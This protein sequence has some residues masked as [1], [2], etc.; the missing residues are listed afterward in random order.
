[1]PRLMAYVAPAD[2]ASARSVK[3]GRAITLAVLVVLIA[4]AAYQAAVA[5]GWLS[6]GPLPGQAP[7]GYGLVLGAALLALVVGAGLCAVYASWPR[8][9]ADA[10]AGLIGPA[11]AAFVVARFY[12][13]DPYY[14]PTLRRMSDDGLVPES[15]VYAVIALA[16]LTAVLAGLR[17]RVALTL[18][19]L[20]LL[21]SAVTALAAGLGH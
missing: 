10:L 12:S 15:W 9:P 19:T 20:V 17:P 2:P 14:A 11:A 3:H 16:L 1:M 4:A 8:P 5:L 6:I 21:L 13:F 7:A 18:T